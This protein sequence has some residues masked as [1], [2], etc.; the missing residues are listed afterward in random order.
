[1]PHF[2]C[3]RRDLRAFFFFDVEVII[4]SRNPNE[5]SDFVGGR[6]SAGIQEPKSRDASFLLAKRRDQFVSFLVTSDI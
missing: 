5:A 6:F 1:M 4:T 2:R 3:P